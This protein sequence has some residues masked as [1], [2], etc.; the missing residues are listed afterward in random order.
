[1]YYLLK[2]NRWLIWPLNAL[3]TLLTIYII[4]DNISN[5]SDYTYDYL[6]ILSK[7]IFIT[8]TLNL[9]TIIYMKYFLYIFNINKG[10]LELCFYTCIVTLLTNLITSNLTNIII[11]LFIKII[12]FNII[13]QHQVINFKLLRLS[14]LICFIDYIITLILSLT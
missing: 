12:L 3:L 9:T 8:I 2:N 6:I 13:L 5:I 14:F 7:I 11:I 10:I 1:M 4:N